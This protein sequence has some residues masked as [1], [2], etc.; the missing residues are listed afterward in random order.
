MK[1]FTPG[2]IT[3]MSGYTPFLDGD[4]FRRFARRQA[5]VVTD[6]IERFTETGIRL[7]SG[8]ELQADIIHYRNRFTSSVTGRNAIDLDD[9]CRYIENCTTKAP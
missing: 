8:K 3:R 5:S 9:R 4:L 6:H 1:H 2:D 7:T